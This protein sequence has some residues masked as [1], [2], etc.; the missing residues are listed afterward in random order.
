MDTKR[1]YV[2]TIWRDSFVIFET[3]NL[4]EPIYISDISIQSLTNEDLNMLKDGIYLD[5]RED[6][7]RL[8]EDYES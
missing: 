2:A 4:E 1:K 7:S 8:L 6:I 5:S 3:S